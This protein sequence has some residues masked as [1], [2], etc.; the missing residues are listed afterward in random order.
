MPTLYG[1]GDRFHM[2]LTVRMRKQDA[3][4]SSRWLNDFFIP[5]PR[6]ING[7]DFSSLAIFASVF[8]YLS[9]MT[10]KMNSNVEA[11]ISRR[12]LSA[13][14]FTIV[15]FSRA[16]SRDEIRGT[17]MSLSIIEVELWLGDKCWWLLSINEIKDALNGFWHLQ[18]QLPCERKSEKSHLACVRMTV[19][20]N[21]ENANQHPFTSFSP[22]N[23]N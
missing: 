8:D 4:T 20:K 23:L 6:D 17:R 2:L 15:F 10:R 11:G 14:A 22:R 16:R 7:R 5:P 12:E 19:W 18:Q 13:E 9:L 3:R 1:R 21:V